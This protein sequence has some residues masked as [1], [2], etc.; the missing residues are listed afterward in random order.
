MGI[1]YTEW[2][3]EKRKWKLIEL[4]IQMFNKIDDRENVEDN[5]KRESPQIVLRNFISFE[6]SYLALVALI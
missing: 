3:E 4:K 1:H 2:N 6:E 5:E